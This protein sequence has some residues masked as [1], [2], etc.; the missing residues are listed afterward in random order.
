MLFTDIFVVIVKFRL[1]DKCV[2]DLK[3]VLTTFLLLTCWFFRGG[4]DFEINFETE[5][6]CVGCVYVLFVYV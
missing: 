5:L 4:G 1:Y 2:F 3:K 6:K